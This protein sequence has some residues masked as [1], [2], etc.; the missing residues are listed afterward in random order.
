MTDDRPTEMV[1]DLFRTMTNCE[2]PSLCAWSSMS[3]DIAVMTTLPLDGAHPFDVIEAC[4]HLNVTD[5]TK[6]DAVGVIL[7]GN[8][9]EMAKGSVDRETMTYE[10]PAD[11]VPTR[12]LVMWVATRD[13]TATL[14]EP[15][16]QGVELSGMARGIQWDVEGQSAEA[17]KA[18]L[19]DR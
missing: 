7:T 3:D 12:V 6:A 2:Q 19:V 10:R 13:F 14:T 5:F 9:F 8:A 4:A 1:L 18:L 11:A 17:L 16:E 15:I